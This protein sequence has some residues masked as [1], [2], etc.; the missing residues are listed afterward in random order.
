MTTPPSRPKLYHI[1][2]VDNLS[3]I[4]QAGGLL[5]DAAMMNAGGPE[6]GIG[7]SQIKRRRLHLPVKCYPGDK[8]GD[9]V[10]FYFC[11]RSIMLYILHRGNLPGLTYEGGQAPILHLEA[12]LYE[13]AAWANAE[14]RRWAFTL[15][16]AGAYYTEFRCQIDR[17]GEINW[18]AVAA[19][20]FRDPKIKE[21]KQAEFLVYEFLPWRLVQRI[22]VYSQVY[23]QQV[24]E[25]LSAHASL[26]QPL[27]EIRRKW[28]Y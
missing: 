15:S 7:I 12:D 9:Y 1:T 13:V 11:P 8:V 19:T 2:H 16:N 28:Y 6:T 23:H 27:V 20:D 21:S 25:I 17:L 26:H 5:S 24:K 22:G 14:N 4:L 18:G 10:P 3:S